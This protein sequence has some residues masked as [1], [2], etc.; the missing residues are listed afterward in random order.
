MVRIHEPV[1]PQANEN[2][3]N[4]EREEAA[5]KAADESVSPKLPGR[6]PSLPPPKPVS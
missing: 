5:Q 4:R 3:Q 1:R 2:R 6:K